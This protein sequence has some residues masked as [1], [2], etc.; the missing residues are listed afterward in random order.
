MLLAGIGI[1]IAA[2]GG[3]I[4]SGASLTEHYI[5]YVKQ[6]HL[7]EKWDTFEND[8]LKYYDKQSSETS[9]EIQKTIRDIISGVIDMNEGYKLIKNRASEASRLRAALAVTGASPVSRVARSIIQGVKVVGSGTVVLNA[10]LVPISLQDL[11]RSANA[12]SSGESSD[13]SAKLKNMA[14]FL[15]KVVN[16]E[17]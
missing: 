15:N 13:V 1:V 7:Q 3:I 2:G 5:N 17:L 12:A 6:Y 11:V 16:D 8:F 10:F 4:D 9:I 14:D